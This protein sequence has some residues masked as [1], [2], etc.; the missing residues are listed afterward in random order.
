VEEESH[1]DPTFEINLE[2]VKSRAVKG[3]AVLTGRTFILNF[4]TFI[5][6]GLLWLFIDPKEFGI[7]LLVSATINFLSYFSDIG[8]G[9]ALIQKREKPNEEDFTTVFTVQEMLVVLI[10][11]I[12]FLISPV[13]RRTQSLEMDGI[14]LLYALN[15]SFF[16]AS[17]K[18]IPSIILER[19]LEFGKF[20]IPQVLENLVY[21]VSVVFFAWQGYGITSFTYAVLL[22]GVVGVIAIYILQPWKPKFGI[23]K[24]SLTSLL[25]F[26]VPYQLNNFLATIKDDGMTIV[27]GKILGAFGLGILGTAQKLAQ[28]PLR[29]F[30]DNVTKVTFP[31][32]SRM[33]DDTKE[34]AR[35]LTRSIF[36]I[37]ALVFPS[38]VGLVI[39]FPALLDVIPKY[40]KWAPA[41][42]PLMLLS[43]CSFWAAATTQLTNFLTS[44]GKIKT[45]FKLMV[46]WT[47][48]TWLLVPAA[49]IVYGI[50]GASL[51]YA[52]IATSSIVVFIL[53]K[54]ILP[55]SIVDSVIKPLESSLVM[56]G[57][58]LVVR[59]L[60]P[61][62]NIFLFAGMVFLG[63]FIY[64]LSLYV[65]VGI[66]LLEDSKRVFS[67][68]FTNK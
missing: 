66:A 10:V 56:G 31:A 38:L 55:W 19:K 44:I 59:H 21:N 62:Y 30:M 37:C 50:N 7:F 11:I 23:S 36:F 24:G 60:L 39:L 4:I 47:S 2:T 33:Q 15:I 26:G 6:Q 29:F 22:R 54:R 13:L 8:L 34:L 1:V 42:I 41:L 25:R 5:A 48:L 57:V 61:F 27:L 45:T 52:V 51:A 68:I 12:I 49:A 14:R 18:N 40:Q 43:I 53:V 20:I 3:I 67:G 35:A 65:L 63:G 28:Y 64:F 32:F 9:A 46:M 58:L 16:L 17:L